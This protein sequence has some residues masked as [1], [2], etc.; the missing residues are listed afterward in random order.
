MSRDKMAIPIIEGVKLTKVFKDF[1]GRPKLTAVDKIDISVKKGGVFGLLGPNGAGKSTLIKMILGHLY[2][3]SGRLAVFQNSPTDVDTKAR[4][5][6]LPERTYFY[7]NLTAEETLRFFGQI[8]E[9]PA[10]EIRARCD[11]LLSMVGLERSRKRMVSEFSRG[12]MRRIGLAQ[13][14]LNDPDLILLD[15]PTA[16]LDPIGCREVKNLILTLAN[17]GKT[18]LLTSHLLADVEDICDE[19]MIMYGGKVM[20]CGYLD[21]LLAEKETLQIRMSKPSD[22]MLDRITN[23]LNNEMLIDELEFSSP[24]RS[25]ENYFLHVVKQASDV[26]ETQ[27][28]QIGK[29]VADYLRNGA[30]ERETILDALT[31]GHNPRDE[32]K[33]QTER[34]ETVEESVLNDLSLSDRKKIKNGKP[35]RETVDQDALDRLSEVNRTRE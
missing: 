1:W 30:V 27:G 14:L 3:T 7:N 33:K 23:L 13:A 15:E 12:M 26:Q 34:E 9:L 17:R 19:V 4:L 11:Q 8:L 28:A 32:S 22:E 6:Y 35:S 16:G 31:I 21:E 25:L 10:A 20:S 5:G 2:P 29:G 24:I 18:I